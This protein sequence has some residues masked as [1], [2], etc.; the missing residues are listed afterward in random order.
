MKSLMWS[1]ISLCLFFTA[2]IDNSSQANVNIDLDP[3]IIMVENATCA[4]KVNQ[5]YLIDEELVFWAVEGN[6][7]DASFN[8]RLFD[9][10]PENIAC[11]TQDS[12]AGPQS[13]CLEK[14]Q[15][16]FDTIIAN[17]GKSDLGLGADHK[18]KQLS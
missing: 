5:L 13:K 15:S 9:K 6:C 17:L 12:I 14:Y 2:C 18:V 10:T 16:L 8:Y 7:S 3:F 4:D 11:Y 1:Y